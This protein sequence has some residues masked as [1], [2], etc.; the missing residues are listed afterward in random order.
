VRN[1]TQPVGHGD[2]GDLKVP[3]AYDKPF[4]FEA[5]PDQSVFFG[6]RFIKRMDFKLRADAFDFPAALF[7]FDGRFFNSLEDFSQSGR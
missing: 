6:R 4:S 5:C 1:D 2:R 3:F 7:L